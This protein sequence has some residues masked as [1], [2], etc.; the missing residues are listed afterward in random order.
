MK[1]NIM[2]N[3]IVLC[4]LLANCFGLFGQKFFTIGDKWIT[5]YKEY[6]GPNA[7]TY[8]SIDSI[9][10]KKDTLIKNKQY[11]QF[12]SNRS[13]ICD[14]Y[15][16]Y[17]YLRQEGQKVYKLSYD[18]DKE[19]L[20]IDFDSQDEYDI[21]TE[22]DGEIIKSTVVIDSVGF[23]EF[24]NGLE[25]KTQFARVLNNQSWED[26]FPHFIYQPGGF[27][28]PGFLFPDIGTGLCDYSFVSQDFKCFITGQDT[29]SFT[30]RG[31][32]EFEIINN[33]VDVY[34][35]QIILSPNPAYHFVKVPDEVEVLS[36]YN[37]NGQLIRIEMSDGKLITSNLKTGLYMIKVKRKDNGQLHFGRFYKI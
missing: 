23:T 22:K 29:F 27:I 9:W 2:K 13:H 35:N 30:D 8:K 1:M 19:Y 16:G 10:A 17:E 24:S 12:V 31:C 26:D 34:D 25:L 7:V 36:L 18:F 6:I 11:I 28:N 4:L 5:E 20:I 14:I 15:G 3:I 21:E 37:S 32:Y 33:A